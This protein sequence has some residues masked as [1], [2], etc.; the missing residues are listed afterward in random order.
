[1]E[2]ANAMLESEVKNV[3]LQVQRK[4]FEQE[5][6]REFEENRQ[7]LRHDFEA[8]RHQDDLR[9]RIANR[10]DDAEFKSEIDLIKVQS[11]TS[12]KTR[13][14]EFERHLIFLFRLC[15][16]TWRRVTTRKE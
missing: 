13:S 3:D 1:M 6:M 12:L 8:R 14:I 11:S 5:M 10:A 15:K 9:Q 2:T 16:Q 7:K 4:L